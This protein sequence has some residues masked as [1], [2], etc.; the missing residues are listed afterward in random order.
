M[1]T[2]KAI[3]FLI[4]AAMGAGAFVVSAEEKALTLT[5]ARAQIDKVV[6][7]PAVMTSVIKQLSA[8]DQKSYLADVNEAISKMPGSAEE[9]TAK[10]INAG[11]AALR[12]A[13]AGNAGDLLAEVFATVPPE[14]LAVLN[15]VFAAEVVNRSGDPSR[16]Y[17]DEQY[18][19]IAKSTVD[20]VAA[21]AAESGEAAVRSA[22]AAM[23]FTRAS[24]GSPADLAA[25]LVDSAIADPKVNALAKNEWLPD[26]LGQGRPKSYDSILGYSDSPAVPDAGT[27]MRLGGPQDSNPLLDNFAAGIIDPATSTVD[28]FG[29]FSNARMGADANLY[30]IPRTLEPDKKWNPEYKR[31]DEPRDEPR[32]Y[33]NTRTH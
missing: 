7:N 12:G 6:E 20:K 19:A 8:A 24:G 2:K 18:T 27:V 13:K 30:R 22:F 17:T 32:P 4:L 5:E 31:G 9:K 28:S 16:T 15:E 33:P 25:T 14:S 3:K 26:G 21:R 23:M 29:D 11:R 10:Y 1:N